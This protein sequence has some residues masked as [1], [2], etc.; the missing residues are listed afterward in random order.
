MHLGEEGGLNRSN[1]IFIFF[2]R[3]QEFCTL[4][5]KDVKVKMAMWNECVCVCAVCVC[6]CVSK[7]ST[8]FSNRAVMGKV[9]ILK[10]L[11]CKN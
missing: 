10:Y 8:F 9:G 6:V 2:I 4:T 3:M 1:S 7:L 11:L 5:G